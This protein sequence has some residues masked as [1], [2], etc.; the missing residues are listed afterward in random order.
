[1]D[2]TI[3]IAVV[4]HDIV[5]GVVDET[6]QRVEKL[7][8]RCCDA[9]VVVLPEMFATGFDVADASVAE[10]PEG[11]VFQ[12]MAAMARRW[13]VAVAGSVAVADGDGCRNRLYFVQ[14]DGSYQY[15]DK[16]HLFTFGGEDRLYRPGDRR[17][18][19]EYKGAR[20]LLQTCYD[21][22]FPV[23]SRNR[24]DYDVAVYVASWPSSR[25][26]AWDALLPARAIE[27]VCCVVAANR[28]GSVGRLAYNGHS[29]IIDHLGRDMA[30]LPSG[31]EGILTAE[32]PLT[33]LRAFRDKF[34]VLSDADDFT[35][36]KWGGVW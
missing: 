29:R 8:E 6:L 22:R 35:I 13:Q 16:R 26:A 3:K 5:S 15:Y 1:M 23:F 12:W 20:I 4:Q 33:A 36:L 2:E 32:I 17:V 27:N 30:T 34:P 7:A 14:P 28:I 10:Q 24:G 18:V 9:D 21:L 31:E 25:I 11:R 19:V